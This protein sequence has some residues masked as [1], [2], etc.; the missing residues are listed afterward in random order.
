MSKE[1]AFAASVI[2]DSQF[3]YIFGGM[4]DFTILKTIEKYDSLSDAW[5]TVFFELPQPLAKLGACMLDRQSIIICGGMSA[6]FEATR[7][8]YQ[9]FLEKSKWV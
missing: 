9:F 3:V 6:D 7:E 1:R 2:L 8:C 5:E 4:L